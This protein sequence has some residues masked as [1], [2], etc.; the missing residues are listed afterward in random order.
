MPS[1]VPQRDVIIDLSPYP[2][3]VEIRMSGAGRYSLDALVGDTPATGPELRTWLTGVVTAH[4]ED[5][6]DYLI[7]SYGDTRDDGIDD[8]APF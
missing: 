5:I 7:A 2:H 1:P 4:A 3:T 8:E 6:A